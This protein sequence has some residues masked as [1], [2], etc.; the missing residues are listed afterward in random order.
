[1]IVGTYSYR[2]DGRLCPYTIP[3]LPPGEY[4]VWIEPLDGSPVAAFQINTR[5]QFTLDTD[6]PEDWYSGAAESGLE[7][8]P[9]DPA[10]A[11][12]VVVTAGR[13]VTGIDIIIEEFVPGWCMNVLGAYRTGRMG[14]SVLVTLVILLHPFLFLYLI[15][16]RM[17]RRP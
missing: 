13:E 10:S 16:K 3:G 17:P 9:N 8:A 4:G 1:M 12:P 6:F 11:V 14:V 7:P 5:I 2:A 15:K